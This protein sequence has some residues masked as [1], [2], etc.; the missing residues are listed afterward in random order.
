[1]GG[2]SFPSKTMK[3]ILSLLI[4]FFSLLTG[5]GSL[6]KDT[7][8]TFKDE[9]GI[10]VEDV[11]VFCEYHQPRKKSEGFN[12]YVSEANGTVRFN[13][14]YIVSNLK[15]DPSRRTYFTYSAKFHAAVAGTGAEEGTTPEEVSAQWH[16]YSSIYR[17]TEIPYSNIN[18][19]SI[20][21]DNSNNPIR[22]LSTLR[23]INYAIKETGFWGYSEDLKGSIESRDL[24]TTFFENEKK[25]FLTKFGE[26]HPNPE[27]LMRIDHTGDLKREFNAEGGLKFKH[28]VQKIK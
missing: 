16:K 12:Y 11:Y 9:R 14:D 19:V 24:I 4:L 17:I 23:I 1:M 6:I 27:Y 28:L 21:K 18:G 3:T 2:K 22:W 25:Q 15:T 7:T 20:I 8:W 10:P 26:D 5:C 13:Q